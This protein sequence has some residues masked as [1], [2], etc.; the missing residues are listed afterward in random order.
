MFRESSIVE[1]VKDISIEKLLMGRLNEKVAI[2]TGAG[3]GMGAAQPHLFAKK[4]P[5][6]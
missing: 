1:L 4:V 6:L 5:K 2:I 3:S